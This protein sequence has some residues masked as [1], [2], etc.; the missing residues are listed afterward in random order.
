VLGSGN[1]ALIYSVFGGDVQDLQVWLKEERLPDGWEPK[2]REA[3][4]HTIAVRSLLISF[5]S[6]ILD[7]G[8]DVL[9]IVVPTASPSHISYD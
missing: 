3:L 5:L 8:L 4:G 9:T 2:N 6:P 1:S 7:S